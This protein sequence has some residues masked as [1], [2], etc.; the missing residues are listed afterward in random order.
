MKTLIFTASAVVLLSANLF[1]SE[2]SNLI[3]HTQYSVSNIQAEYCKAKNEK[4]LSFSELEFSEHKN[5]L[6]YSN[7]LSNLIF[8]SDGFYSWKDKRY[9]KFENDFSKDLI[10]A[11]ENDFRFHV[12]CGVATDDV[13]MSEKNSPSNINN[14][15]YLSK[16]FQKVVE[17]WVFETARNKA[18]DESFGGMILGASK[19]YIPQ[20]ITIE[21]FSLRIERLKLSTEKSMKKITD[22]EK[23]FY[24]YED[25][26]QLSL[27]QVKNKDI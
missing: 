3:S 27:A 11:F 5:S 6:N 24:R 13:V 16:E 8:L 22:N 20:S 10:F 26:M 18:I 1:A 19:E 14:I 4:I 12:F 15:T 21:E 9:F 2:N 23:N 7:G 25:F 17:N